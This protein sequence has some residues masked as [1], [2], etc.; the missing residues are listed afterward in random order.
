MFFDPPYSDKAS[1]CRLYKDQ[2]FSIGAAVRQ[3]CKE[4]G[5]RPT[6]RIVLAGFEGEGHEEL[7]TLGWRCVEWFKPGFG[8]RGYAAQSEDGSNQHRERLWISPHCLQEDMT[9]LEDW[10]T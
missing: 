5:N 10:M 8:N 3:W 1:K 6:L 9:T 4:N 2:D 7:E